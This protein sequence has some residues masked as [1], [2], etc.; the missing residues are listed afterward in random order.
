MVKKLRE[1]YR[2]FGQ[3]VVP[4]MVELPPQVVAVELK[5]AAAVAE[6]TIKMTKPAVIRG[7]L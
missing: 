7:R 4:Q 6:P 5:Q 3:S 1:Y 2:F